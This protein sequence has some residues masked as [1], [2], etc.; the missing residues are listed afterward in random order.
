MQKIKFE[1]SLDELQALITLTENQFFRIKFLDPKMPGYKGRPAEVEAAQ[2]AIVV[3]KE[4]L[5][6]I[7]G[8]ENQ[9]VERKSVPVPPA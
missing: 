9:L 6:M 4:S 8:S 3:L 2:S 5:R 1:L 7:T